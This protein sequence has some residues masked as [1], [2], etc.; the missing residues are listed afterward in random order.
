MKP[1]VF[2]AGVNISAVNWKAVCGVG[3]FSYHYIMIW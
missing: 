3:K 2:V 1:M